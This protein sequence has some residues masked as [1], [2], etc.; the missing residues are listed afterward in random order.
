MNLKDLKNS[1]TLVALFVD[2]VNNT[3]TLEETLYS[4]SKQIYSVDLLVLHP[5]LSDDNLKTL[6]ECLENPK[7]IL[8][9]QNSEGG[10]DEETIYA[11]NKLNF[12]LAETEKDNFPKLFNQTFNIAIKNDY[13]FISFIEPN[14]IVG[15]DLYNNA[16]IYASENQ[17]LAMFFPIIRNTVNGVFNNLINEA[18]WVEGFSEEAGVIDLNLLNRFNCVIPLGT[19]FRVNA[20][21]EYSEQKEDGEYYPMKESIK[22]SHYYEFLLRMVYNDVKGISVPRIGYEFRVKSNDA[23]VHTS[24]KIPQDIS[25]ISTENGVMSLEEGKFWLDLAKKEYF[26]DEDRN[27]VYESK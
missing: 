2:N 8:R 18:T 17:K 13:E 12:I 21:K 27:K 11:E 16:N 20:I 4:V 10:F 9:K 23:F 7:I 6:K 25:L 15:I 1:N 14:D 24:C 22:L 19:T 26:F 5:S 3:I